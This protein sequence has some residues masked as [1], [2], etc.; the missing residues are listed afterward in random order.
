MLGY[1]KTVLKR[2]SLSF[3][4]MRLFSITILLSLFLTPPRQTFPA[5]YALVTDQGY[6]TIRG[7]VAVIN[8]NKKIVVETIDVGINPEGIIA[9]GTADGGRAYVANSGS[10]NVSVIPINVP[11]S[12]LPITINAYSFVYVGN[13]PISIAFYETNAY[14]VN[15]GN[16][17]ISTIDTIDQSFIETTNYPELINP[18]EI[19]IIEGPES[20][21]PYEPSN[22]YPTDGEMGVSVSTYLSWEGGDP[23]LPDDNVIY[24]V[25]MGADLATTGLE[26]VC[27]GIEHPNTSCTPS[28]SP[29][30]YGTTYYWMVVA[31]DY[32]GET[33]ESPYPYWSFTTEESAS[34]CEVTIIPD[35]T[36]VNFGETLQFSASTTCNEADVSGDYI[37]DVTSSIGSIIDENGLYTAGTAEGLDIV[38]V[39]DIA[40]GDVKN[41]AQVTVVAGPLCETTISPPSATVYSNETI[42][43]SATTTPLSPAIECVEGFYLW[44]V[45]SPIG[46]SITQGG[47]YTAGVNDTEEDIADIVIVTDTANGS[48]TNVAEVT[49]LAEPQQEYIVVIT[50]DEIKLASLETF[51]FT[52]QTLDAETQTPIP[53]EECKYRWE[54]SPRSTIRSTILSYGEY[55]LYTAGLNNTRDLLTETVRVYDTAHNDVSATAT[56]TVLVRYSSFYLPPGPL[57]TSYR[58]ISI[59]LWPIDGDA[60]RI[61]TGRTFDEYKP[62]FRRFIRLFIWDGELNDGQGGYIEYPDPGFPEL[63]PGIGIWVI[64]L[65]G[66]FIYVDG[67]PIDTSQDFT[68]T[69][70]PGWTQIGHPFPFAVD[71]DNVTGVENEVETPWTF[72]GS[73]LQSRSLHP[74]HG[75]F[76]YNNSSSTVTISIPSQESEEKISKTCKPLSEKEKGWQLQ[77]GVHNILLFWSHDTYNFIGVSEGSSAERDLKD[78]HEPP[79]ISPDQVS[80]YFSHEWEG[81]PEQF[82]TDF[83]SLD[84]HKEVFECTVNPGSGIISLMR[85]FWSDI[86]KVPEEYQL[87]FTDPETGIT[88]NMREV[89]EYWF[90]SYLDIEKHFRISMTKN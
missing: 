15:S 64:T 9:F 34:T 57:I 47:L 28:I 30:E 37:W 72:V 35:S 24:D 88:V 80:L 4:I 3:P 11:N 83:R 86:A 45:D 13:S 5:P 25:F 55:A 41:T 87:E 89:N 56:V 54:I 44:E 6:G 46:S 59:P 8:L 65:P 77:I 74:W 48:I 49:V 20:L 50:P 75:Y 1:Y 14:V 27:S 85:L 22:S 40:N 29:L 12:G 84:S 66:G 63:E 43:F 7:R 31:T 70:P 32:N 21:P 90:F 58:M 73:Y 38:T 79:P 76:V 81:K 16:R 17:S 36:I 69:L 26:Q 10:N 23:D 19:A 51:R 33:S 82:T 42:T 52:A 39:L 78:L 2:A 60:L 71:W 18:V 53:K 62:F 68:I 61:I 67:T